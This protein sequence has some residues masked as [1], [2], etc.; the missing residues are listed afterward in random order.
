[1]VNVGYRQFVLSHMFVDDILIG[2]R[3]LH[4][5]GNHLTLVVG[6]APGVCACHGLGV[7]EVW[8]RLDGHILP[9]QVLLIKA[10][11]DTSTG[12]IYLLMWL[13][14]VQCHALRSRLKHHLARVHPLV[15]IN[16]FFHVIGVSTRIICIIKSPNKCI[17]TF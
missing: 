1:M 15:S 9:M 4:G 10:R 5:F 17:L 16:T 13:I 6:K 14:T 2:G 12:E 11:L 3:P 8:I 7:T